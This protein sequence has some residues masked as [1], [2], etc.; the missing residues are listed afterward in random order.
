MDSVE[1]F[2]SHIE[3]NQEKPKDIRILLLPSLCKRTHVEIELFSFNIELWAK[4][5][6][7]QYHHNLFANFS[8]KNFL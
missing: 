4:N 1:S 7:P 2:S 3:K 5:T 6:N 8:K